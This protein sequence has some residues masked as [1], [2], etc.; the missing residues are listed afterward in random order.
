M[1]RYRRSTSSLE[2]PQ[3][4]KVD[5]SIF[6]R[7]RGV[8]RGS[9]SMLST[10]LFTHSLNQASTSLGLFNCW[11]FILFRCTGSSDPLPRMIAIA[12]DLVWITESNPANSWVPCKR[13]TRS[14]DDVICVMRPSSDWGNLTEVQRVRLSSSGYSDSTWFNLSN[15]SRILDMYSSFCLYSNF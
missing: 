11:P 6:S 12:S 13:C 2:I 3:F 8:F 9:L 14:T 10:Q 1:L 15:S 7:I 4:I 5:R